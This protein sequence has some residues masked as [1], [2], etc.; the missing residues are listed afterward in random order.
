MLKVYGTGN[1]LTRTYKRHTNVGCVTAWS[2]LYHNTWNNS[3][4]QVLSFGEWRKA[5]ILSHHPQI[6]SNNSSQMFLYSCQDIKCFHQRSLNKGL[7]S[8][9]YHWVQFSAR[10]GFHDLLCC[11]KY[12]WNALRLLDREVWTQK[13]ALTYDSILFYYEFQRYF[14]R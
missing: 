9:A 10:L 11:K 3:A 4:H 14:A 12:K 5:R 6:L 2:E 7:I 8:N 1:D 13:L